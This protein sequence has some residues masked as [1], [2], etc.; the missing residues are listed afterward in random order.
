MPAVPAVPAVPVVAVEPSPLTLVPVAVDVSLAS[1][2][3]VVRAL[4]TTVVGEASTAARPVRARSPRALLGVTEVPVVPS[5]VPG[6]TVFPAAG[7]AVV[8]AAG[9]ARVALVV[10]PTLPPTDGLAG[11]T[12]AWAAVPTASAAARIV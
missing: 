5:V 8:P 6:V 2:G 11:P 1:G 10:A 3:T 9:A 7:A 4:G 12:C